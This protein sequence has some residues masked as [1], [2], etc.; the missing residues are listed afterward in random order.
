MADILLLCRVSK[1]WRLLA[2][3][4]HVKMIMPPRYRRYLT[5]MDNAALASL[6]QRFP[7]V[8]TIRPPRFVTI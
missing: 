4:E 2:T 3:I 7:N 8:H 5:N 1:G 6:V